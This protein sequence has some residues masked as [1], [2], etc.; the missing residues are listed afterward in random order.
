[1][2]ERKLEQM[3]PNA[4]DRTIKYKKNYKAHK[5]KHFDQS[6]SETRMLMSS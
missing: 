4:H 1:M 2:T 5:N 6:G 3:L